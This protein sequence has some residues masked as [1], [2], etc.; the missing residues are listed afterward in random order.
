MQAN[1]DNQNSTFS[2][3][4]Y[5]VLTEDIVLNDGYFEEDG[6]YHDGGDGVLYTWTT[7]YIKDAYIDGQNHVISGMYIN[8]ETQTD[9][10]LFYG[11]AQELKNIKVNNVYL[12]ALSRVAGVWAT[13]QAH[14]TIYNVHNLG[15][16]LKAQ[17][18]TL[19]GVALYTYDSFDIAENCTNYAKL[20]QTNN[21]ER[22]NIGGICNTAKKI[23]HCSNYGDI[24]ALLGSRIGGIGSWNER[25]EYSN[26]YGDITVLAHDSSRAG[27]Y[28]GISGIGNGCNIKN[29]KNYGN[30]ST[31]NTEITGGIYGR[32]CTGYSLDI[33]NC[34]NY[35]YIYGSAIYGYSEGKVTIKHCDNYG[36]TTRA[37]VGGQVL[38]GSLLYD[39]KNYGDVIMTEKVFE[40]QHGFFIDGHYKG[41]ATLI[42]C[43][44]YGNVSGYMPYYS[45]IAAH[46]VS[47]KTPLLLCIENFDMKAKFNIT[48]GN[49]VHILPY[50]NNIILQN[51]KFEIE[52]NMKVALAGG[53]SEAGMVEINNIEINVKTNVTKT[54][55]ILFHGPIKTPNVVIKNVLIN[56]VGEKYTDVPD[57][58]FDRVVEGVSIEGIIGKIT[59]QKKVYLQY[60]GDNFSD[61]YYS[62][63]QG[64]IGIKAMNSVGGFQTSITEQWLK[65][66]DYFKIEI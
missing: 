53:I 28:G 10:S 27:G 15:G 30:I 21:E 55:L 43:G 59:S 1:K 45:G 9:V 14:P 63:K 49:Y 60:F 39:C 66:K 65:N 20:I 13:N 17:S 56:D 58:F 41:K 47:S 6:T 33:E 12:N 26:N 22:I 25:V 38:N 37:F 32:G 51:S 34:T 29:C 46:A 19:C 54:P 16:Y 8:D 24:V 5:F 18:G 31:P 44:M 40:R 3:W 36:T 42:D 48:G 64:K 2:R 35:G 11:W 23:T 7:I 57:W 50:A 61:F 4:K 62:N 52:S